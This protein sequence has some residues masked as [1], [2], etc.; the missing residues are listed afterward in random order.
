MGAHVSDQLRVAGFAARGL[1]AAVDYTLIAFAWALLIGLLEVRASVSP[2]ARGLLYLLLAGTYHTLGVGRWGRTPGKKLAAV[3]V[4]RADGQPIGYRLAF[5]RWLLSVVTAPLTILWRVF[6]D[7]SRRRWIH[8][9]L[10]DTSALT[11]LPDTL[12]A[13]PLVR[14]QSFPYRWRLASEGGQYFATF[15]GYAEMSDAQQMFLDELTEALERLRPSKV[16]PSETRAQ[17]LREDSDI[18]LELVIPHATERDFRLW[19][20]VYDNRHL[21]VGLRGEA[22]EAHTHWDRWLWQ[23]PDDSDLPWTSEAVGD[24]IDLLMGRFEVRTVYVGDTVRRATVRYVSTR[25]SETWTWMAPSPPAFRRL[26]RRRTVKT[27]SF[28]DERSPGQP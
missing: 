17:L 1:A 13:P 27:F 24:V 12:A 3:R 21:I 5:L 4:V 16:N 14:P 9:L 2:L 19:L 20:M 26:P 15:A 25:S 7:G 8:D 6:L 11:T 22:G 28:V 10:T 18:A 23:S